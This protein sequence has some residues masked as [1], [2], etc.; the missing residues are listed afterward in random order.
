MIQS[1]QSSP[2]FDA[3]GWTLIHSVWQI[4]LVGILLWIALN[5]IS[6]KSPKLSYY[7]SLSSLIIICLMT[8]FTFFNNF[9][10][11]STTVELTNLEVPQNF[12]SKENDIHPS[13]LESTSFENTTISSA[14]NSYVK[15]ESF[16][17]FVVLAWM[18]GVLFFGIKFSFSWKYIHFLKK[19]KTSLISLKWQ[20][21]IDQFCQKM[22]IDKKVNL[23]LS[24]H[25]NS[26][27]TFGHFKPIVLFPTSMLTGLS[28]DQIEML[29]L[30]EL[31]HIRR[32][33]F[34][35]N[36]IQSIIEVVL[37]Y[38][39]IVWWISEQIRITREH[40]CDDMAI[41]ICQNHFL[42][43]ET[44]TQLQTSILLHKKSLAM[45]AKR[46]S[47]T[48]TYRI[49]RLF[50]TAES[51]P[52]FIKSIFSFGLIAVCFSMFA[53]QNPMIGKGELKKYP[54]EGLLFVLTNNNVQLQLQ[55]IKQALKQQNVKFE[56]DS[57]FDKNHK[58]VKKLKGKI[59]MPDNSFVRFSINKLDFMLISLDWTRR[60]PLS[61]L[62]K[63]NS[64]NSGTEI[65]N[66]GALSVELK[67]YVGFHPI[68]CILDDLTVGRYNNSLKAHLFLNDL[69]GR[70]PIFILDGEKISGDELE[71]MKIE[72][73]LIS[74]IVRLNRKVAE[75]EY[76]EEE[77]RDGV[78]H[79]STWMK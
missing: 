65:G 34:L 14:E 29:L 60:F 31:A 58:K 67:R 1:F 16:F 71:A 66:K 30:H 54:N 41:E 43:A 39:P 49:Q 5:F 78:Y 61:T 56:Y 40:C 44:L 18:I 53:F 62:V 79:I 28:P 33:D 72:V 77:I 63:S 23:F 48:F 59:I 55:K 11:T 15:L 26:P 75:L 35:I 13:S 27:I 8:G 50:Q 69:N 2:L 19:T 74:S 7:F 37:F 4:I 42:Y 36:L 76:P 20:N 73:S 52:S 17:P 32:A 9:D 21:Q 45:S 64:S 12:E 57:D 10:F 38:H 6:K 47:G 24:D 68:G 25:I 51:K 3:I 46:N 70:S 22:N